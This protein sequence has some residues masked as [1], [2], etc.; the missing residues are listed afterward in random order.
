MK[1]GALWV[2]YRGLTRADFGRDRAVATAGESGKVLFFLCEE[3]NAWFHWFS[4]G[5]ISRD[6]CK[7]RRSVSR[8]KLSE[9]NFE[10][11]TVS[12]VFPKQTQNLKISKIFNFMRLQAA[13]TL[14]WLQITGNSL[15]NSPLRISSFHFYRWNQFKVILLA[16]TLRTRNVLPNSLPR[17]WM[18]VHDTP[19]HNA[20]VAESLTSKWAWPVDV[21][22]PRR[23]HSIII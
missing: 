21:I 1:S 8:W 5:Q 19:C 15:P 12:V 13:I 18:P 22:R 10:N 2:R 7:T 20:N 11:L 4:V 16:C 23:G 9:Q 3:N 17:S 14:Q 6:L